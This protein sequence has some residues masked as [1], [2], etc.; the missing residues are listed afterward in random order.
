MNRC[1][2]QRITLSVCCFSSVPLVSLTLPVQEYD[3]GTVAM[4]NDTV[5]TMMSCGYEDQN[6]EIGLIIGP[7][8]FYFVFSFYFAPCMAV[9]VFYCI[10]GKLRF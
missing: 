8:S 5:G 6:C 1:K 2:N 4:V 10:L 9:L 3:I 7:N